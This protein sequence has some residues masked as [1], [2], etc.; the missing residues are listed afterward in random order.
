[1]DVNEFLAQDTTLDD[2]VREGNLDFPRQV[3]ARFLKRSDERFATVM[4]LLKHKPDFK[5]DESFVD[6]PEHID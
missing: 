5:V 4:E 2:K 3:F 1:P 6:D